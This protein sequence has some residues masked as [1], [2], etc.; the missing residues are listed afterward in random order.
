M[1]NT[2]S[3]PRKTCGGCQHLEP[4]RMPFNSGLF[5][6]CSKT[7]KVVPHQSSSSVGSSDWKVVLWRVPLECPLPDA[8]VI[9]SAEKAPLKNWEEMVF[10]GEDL[11]LDSDEVSD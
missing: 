6:G 7:G 3:T 9:K 10:E 2:Q 1:G 8:D 4:H 11:I 5:M